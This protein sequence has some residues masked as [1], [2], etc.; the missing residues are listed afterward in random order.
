MLYTVNIIIYRLTTGNNTMHFKS[1]T[2]VADAIRNKD[3]SPVELTEAMLS[4]VDTLNPQLKAY[5]TIT[6]DLAR[7]QAKIAEQEISNGSYK[8]MLHGVPIAVKDLFDTAGI[9]TA[10]GS[11]IK[12]ENVPD[13]N[14]TVVEKL[15]ASGSILLGKLNMTEFALSGYHPDM[16]VPVNPWGADRWAGVSS[17][18]PGV[19][20]AAG[21]AY[22]TLGTDTGGSRRFPS[23][24]NGVVGI[25]PTYGTAS[26]KGAFPL[27]Y[28]LDHVG[29]I[30]RTVEDAAVLLQ[31]IAGFDATDP[32][33]RRFEAPDYL[34]GVGKSING[35][36]IGLDETYCATDAHPEVTAAVLEAARVLEKLGAEIVPVDVIGILEVCPYWGAVVAAEAMVTHADTY[37]DRAGDYGPVFRSALDAAPHIPATDYAAAQAARARVTAILESVLIDVDA[38]VCPSAPLPAMPLEEFP[39]TLVLP[40]EAVASFV[41]FMAPTNFS[42]HPTISL[43]CGFSSDELPLGMQLIGRYENEATIISAAHRYER[44]AGWHERHPRIN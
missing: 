42:G 22:G 39:P 13:T 23:A 15:A 25:K 41:G 28:T 30:A 37:A 7:E 6:A 32:F 34:E 12:E 9:K 38:L 5:A 35:L 3:I 44:E 36:R 17:S 20:T 19:A 40:P 10:C 11:I 43:P 21:L 24:V 4:R 2:E 33:S 27:A 31:A 29:P 1:L 16:P 14:A 8:G 18:G 26:T